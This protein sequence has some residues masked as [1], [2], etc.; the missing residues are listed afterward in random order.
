MGSKHFS[1]ESILS[2]GAIEY[3][4]TG[5]TPDGRA[6]IYLAACLVMVAWLWLPQ[7]VSGQATSTAKD[8]SKATTSTKQSTPAQAQ[9][10][11]TPTTQAPTSTTP[12][13]D[14]KAGG[15]TP[16][17]HK[18]GMRLSGSACLSC[19]KELEKKIA[20]ITGVKSAKVH[21]PEQTYHSYEAPLTLQTSTAEIIFDANAVS[22]DALRIFLK[23]KG[24][25]PF[26]V[27]D[28]KQ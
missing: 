23:Q 6:S 3:E 10:S 19:L 22:A 18:L 24:Y 25:Y 12:T 5:S 20:A 8:N 17:W 21:P 27:V 13:T 11:A 1:K 4:Q 16:E 7:F 15:S 2:L 9:A 28:S 14:T 26:K